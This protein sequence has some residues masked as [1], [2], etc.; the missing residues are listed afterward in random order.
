MLWKDMQ[1]WDAV[2][3]LV[4][5][6]LEVHKGFVRSGP[7]LLFLSI[8]ILVLEVELAQSY[9][10]PQ[11]RPDESSNRYAG[12]YSRGVWMVRRLMHLIGPC[13]LPLG[14]FGLRH[15][16]STGQEGYVA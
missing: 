5:P 3:W 10:R 13:E 14:I 12:C 7:V 9:S 2:E 8:W 11:C 6:E 16:C 4:E 15:V 1:C